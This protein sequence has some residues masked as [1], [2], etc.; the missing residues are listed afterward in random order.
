MNSAIYKSELHIP[1][2]EYTKVICFDGY[3]FYSGIAVYYVGTDRTIVRYYDY[4]SVEGKDLLLEDFQVYASAFYENMLKNG[5]LNGGSSFEYF[6]NN[7]TLEDAKEYY[8]TAKAAR[9]EKQNPS[10]SEGVNALVWI[11]PTAVAV[12]LLGGALAFV[13]YRKK[14]S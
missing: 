6:V 8:E 9:L 4:S 5:H 14:K 7:Y 10:D 11:I 1:G 3:L 13:T 12:I 2:M